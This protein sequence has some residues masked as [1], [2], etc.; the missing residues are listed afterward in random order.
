G[1]TALVRFARGRDQADLRLF[2][3]RHERQFARPYFRARLRQRA[4]YRGLHLRRRQ[5]RFSQ[6][7][8][9]GPAGRAGLSARRAGRGLPAIHHRA[10]ARLQRLSLRSHPRRPDA[11][12]LAA[13]DLRALGDV[14]RGSRGAR[15]GAQPLRLARAVRDGIARRQGFGPPAQTARKGRRGRRIRRRV[16]CG[17]WLRWAVNS[18][19]LAKANELA[20]DI[21][22]MISLAH[23][24]MESA[25][26]VSKWGDSLAVRLPKTLVE[27]MGLS[28]GDELNIVD[29]AERTL[30]VQKEDRRKAALERLASLNW[31]LPADY[32]F[33]RDEANE[34]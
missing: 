32:K 26:L 23:Y 17:M 24:A 30:V 28:A 14:G 20:N 19:G 27:K 4:G 18:R 12:R 34:R 5:A 33:D 1:G 21:I 25:M 9:E 6:G 22:I 16:G 2:L 15:Y 10:G 7:R 13:A 31:T 8:L 29:V 11:P 3:P